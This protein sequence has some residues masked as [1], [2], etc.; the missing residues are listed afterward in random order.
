MHS[1]YY[2][3]VQYNKVYKIRLSYVAIWFLINQP[4][5]KR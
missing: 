3:I 1:N 4:W 2:R 5:T